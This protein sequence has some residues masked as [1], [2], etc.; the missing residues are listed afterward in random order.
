MNYT[1][2]LLPEKPVSS[3]TVNLALVLGCSWLIAL[4]AQYSIQLPISPVPITG[5]TLIVLLAGLV[6]GKNRAAA[7]GAV[8]R[9]LG[10]RPPPDPLHAVSLRGL[11]G[12]VGVRTKQSAS[13][14]CSETQYAIAVEASS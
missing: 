5:Q 9:G 4:S 10:L 1:D 2:I 3:R 7:A 8:T 13:K 14:G 6:L 12:T 11:R